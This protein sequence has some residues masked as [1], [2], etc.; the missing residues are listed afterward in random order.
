M[1]PRSSTGSSTAAS[2]ATLSRAR[3]A[4]GASASSLARAR[5]LGSRR[6]RNFPGWVICPRQWSDKT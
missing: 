5:L 1:W 3:A 2:W 6:L 4:W